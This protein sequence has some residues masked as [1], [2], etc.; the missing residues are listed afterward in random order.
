M[1]LFD[2]PT[3][4]QERL[5]PSSASGRSGPSKCVASELESKSELLSKFLVRPK[6]RDAL[7]GRL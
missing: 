7:E 1:A 6:D 3:G 4:I 2:R 5:I